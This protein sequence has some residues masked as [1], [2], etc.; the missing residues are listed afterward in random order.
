[1]LVVGANGLEEVTQSPIVLVIEQ[2]EIHA[3]FS[4]EMNGV[5][6]VLDFEAV[7]D[8]MAVFILGGGTL[9][10]CQPDGSSMLTSS[11]FS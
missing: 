5:M 2:K 9:S 6:V 11:N 8:N 10:T 7:I 4:A 1:L 3:E